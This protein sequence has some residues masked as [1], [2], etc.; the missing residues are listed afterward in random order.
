MIE[1]S[2]PAVIGLIIGIPSFIL[3]WLGY[4]RA[5]KVD[6]SVENASVIAAQT[7]SVAQIITG[8]NSVIDNLQ[9]DNKIW[10][11][12][13]KELSLKLTEVIKE[14]DQIQKD[15]NALAKKFGINNTT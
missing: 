12:N 4:K 9:E 7:G 14:R 13:F 8:L 2:H 5:V 11:D 10:R 1:W 6:K 3:G 15:Y